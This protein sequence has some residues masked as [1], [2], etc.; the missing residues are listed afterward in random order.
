MQLRGV[1]HV[2]PLELVMTRPPSVPQSDPAPSAGGTPP[3]AGSPQVFRGVDA[4]GVMLASVSSKRQRC[5]TGAPQQTQ[6]CTVTAHVVMAYVVMAHKVTAYFV[7][8]NMVM[9]CTV[10]ANMLMTD[11]VVA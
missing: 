9:A 8:G 11:I 7:V 10:M 2:Q 3:A 1:E 5:K 6:V 4:Q